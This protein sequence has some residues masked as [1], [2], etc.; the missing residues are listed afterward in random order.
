MFKIEN[1]VLEWG[2][3]TLTLETGRV[4]RQAHGSVIAT[5]GGTSV[6]ATVVADYEPKPGLD[7]FPLTVNYQEKAY[8]AGKIPGGFF[9]R[10]GR[11]SE[12]ETLVSR[13]IDRPIRPLFAK[14][15][16]NETQ[17]LA[18]V[19][20]YDGENDPDIVAIIAAS[21]AL[22]L[23]GLPFMG[24]IGA[25]RVGWDGK[26]YILNPK[27]NKEN[28]GLLDLVVAGTNDG[29][30]MVESEASELN[31]KIMLGA[32]DFGHKELKNVIKGIIELA[33]VAAKEPTSI[34]EDIPE[35]KDYLKL[36]KGFKKEIEK[37]YKIQE[38]SSR[39]KFSS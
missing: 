36:V 12:K 32:V 1:E 27:I 9:K 25:C 28:K 31:E 30:L 37:A 17:V 11:P 14:G 3:K 18:T 26:N 33:E 24:P 16:Q 7:F 20:S 38:K 13:L 34:D 29:V 22:T 21:A 8:A 10:E 2:G 23:S 35:E 39:Y 19:I 4:A 6:L 15:F 5:Y